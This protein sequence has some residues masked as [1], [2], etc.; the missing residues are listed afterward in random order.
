MPFIAMAA[1]CGTVSYLLYYKAI[2]RLGAAR[3]MALNITY[4]AWTIPFS[5]IMLGAMPDLRGVMCA[6]LIIAGA[7]VA[8]TDL[9]SLLGAPNRHA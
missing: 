2:A 4:S 9:P 6:L 3:A 8:A 5:L 1:F 7:I